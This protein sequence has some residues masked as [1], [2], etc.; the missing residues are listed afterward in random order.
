MD[1]SEV[2]VHLHYTIVQYKY[3]ILTETAIQAITPKTRIKLAG[4]LECTE[5]WIIKLI[6]ANKSNGPLTTYSALKVIREDTGLPDDEL[7]RESAE[8]ELLGE[9]S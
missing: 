6:A 2:S 5:Q 7:L 9:Q 1:G 8:E 3:M 4:A